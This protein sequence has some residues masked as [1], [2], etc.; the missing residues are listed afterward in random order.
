MKTPLSLGRKLL[1]VR[2]KHKT[3]SPRPLKNKQGENMKNII[4]AIKII[5][6]VAL[7]LLAI[8]IA[9]NTDQ[10]EYIEANACYNAKV[11]Q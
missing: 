4:K 3:R 9:G 10:D 5:L 7:T 11:C 2:D 8:G 1:G 6:V